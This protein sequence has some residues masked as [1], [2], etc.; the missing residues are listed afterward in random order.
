M[1]VYRV[2]SF[3]DIELGFPSEDNHNVMIFRNKEKA[4]EKLD[5][6]FYEYK[7]HFNNPDGELK[8]DKNKNY[9][10]I[11]DDTSQV[12]VKITEEILA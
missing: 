11:S 3:I 8:I 4:F 7:E 12:I 10:K 5:S 9:F 6:L 1:K 2:T